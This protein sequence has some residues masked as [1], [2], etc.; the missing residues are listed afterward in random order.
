MM[1]PL[2]ALAPRLMASS[3]IRGA[4]QRAWLRQQRPLRMGIADIRLRV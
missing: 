3:A 2:L 4:I 1:K